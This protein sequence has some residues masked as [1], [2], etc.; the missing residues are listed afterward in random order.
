MKL[1]WTSVCYKCNA[2]LHP[3]ISKTTSE[4]RKL[5]SYYK[6]IRPI[7][8]INNQSRYSFVGRKVE[9][10]CYWCF[11]N[12]PKYTFHSLKEREIGKRAYVRS[13]SKT[14]NEIC[15]WF[16]GLLREANN[17]SRYRV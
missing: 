5:I 1:K 14:V 11:K 12:V 13:R 3:S 4:E 10:V 15:H 9:R 17:R 6:R 8:M 16:D 2:P 7:F